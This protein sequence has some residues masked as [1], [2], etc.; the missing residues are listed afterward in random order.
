MFKGVG[1]FHATQAV[2]D[3][4][5]AMGASKFFNEGYASILWPSGAREKTR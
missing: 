3:F 5:I 4:I 1:V 2:I